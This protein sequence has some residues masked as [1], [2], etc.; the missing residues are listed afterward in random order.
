M[1][2]RF[3]CAFGR[4]GLIADA[5]LL[6]TLPARVGPATAKRLL[7]FGD[8]LDGGRRPLSVSPR[9]SASPDPPGRA[10]RLAGLLT[11]GAP[12]AMEETTR[13][14]ASWPAGL[15]AVLTEEARTQPRLPPGADF[16]KKQIRQGRRRNHG[17][18][19]LSAPDPGR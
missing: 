2:A 18:T 9:P 16:A 10:V 19:R 6:W 11:E 14:L 12:S 7:L 4:I 15:E 5:G 17:D 13:I 1:N 3:G 8:V